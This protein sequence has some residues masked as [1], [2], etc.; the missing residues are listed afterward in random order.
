MI[1]V[2]TTTTLT[3]RNARHELDRMHLVTL[4]TDHGTLAQRCLAT[5]GQRSILAGLNLPEPPRF[6]DFAPT[7]QTP[8]IEP[9]HG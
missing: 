4:T 7:C 1:R 5:P 3:W 9:D 2:V 6:C 8:G